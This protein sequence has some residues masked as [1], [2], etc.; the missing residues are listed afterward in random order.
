MSKKGG[1]L[2]GGP[3]LVFAA[4]LFGIA[5]FLVHKT[6]FTAERPTPEPVPVTFMCSETGKV[7]EHSMTE[8]EHWPVDSPY[9][10]KKTGYPVERCYW[11]PDGKRKAM[12]TFVILNEHLGKPGD[13]ICPDC[14][15]V[16][17][18]HN[19][20]PPPDV[21]FADAPAG[22]SEPAGASKALPGSN[23]SGSSAEN[24]ARQKAETEEIVYATVR[25]KMEEMIAERAAML[26]AGRPPNDPTIRQFENAIINARDM[27]IQRGEKLP[28]II[29][30]IGGPAA[31]APA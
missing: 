25:A 18:G 27:L 9:T 1:R 19:P 17:V 2:S 29:P 15:R 3:G 24:A 21:P 26:Q 4:I 20:P 8:G 30:P 22:T 23:R 28:E 31:S 6:L 12:P 5:G 10:G 13:T 14:K 7:F 16:V 11:T